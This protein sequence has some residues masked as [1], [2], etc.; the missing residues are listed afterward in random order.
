MIDLLTIS[1]SLVDNGR[2]SCLGRPL[3][4]DGVI[5]FY[6]GAGGGVA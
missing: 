2:L 5:I 1:F 3:D 6:H 4:I